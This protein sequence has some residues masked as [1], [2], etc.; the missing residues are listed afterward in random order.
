MSVT[1]AL[2]PCAPKAPRPT[3][4]DPEKPAIVHQN[5]LFESIKPASVESEEVSVE[6]SPTSPTSLVMVVSSV[7]FVFSLFDRDV[8]V[9]DMFVRVMDGRG[10]TE[11]GI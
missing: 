4:S 6:D 7:C 11:V 9:R 8:R 1:R 5:R 2:S 10:W 3:A